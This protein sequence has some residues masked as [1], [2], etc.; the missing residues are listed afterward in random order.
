MYEPLEERLK[1]RRKDYI[2]DMKAEQLA[3]EILKQLSLILPQDAKLNIGIYQSYISIVYYPTDLDDTE[4]NIIPQISDTFSTRWTKTVAK[5]EISYHTEFDTEKYSCIL[6]IYPS[7]TG[8]CRIDAIPTGR[9]IKRDK[10]VSVDE[11][12]FDF[13]VNCND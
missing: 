3:E 2:K 13:V 9:I 10:Y 1:Q 5:N 11:Q 8:S 12:E 6:R 7:L 4:I